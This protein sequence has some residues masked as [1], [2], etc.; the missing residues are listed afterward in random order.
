MSLIAE[1]IAK[2]TLPEEFVPSEE[3]PLP[4]IRKDDLVLELINY[5]R[6]REYLKDKP[7]R[8]I[9]DLALICRSVVNTADKQVYAAVIDR[10]V[11]KL[12]A[13]S[14]DE[15]FRIA[16][17]PDERTH[18]VQAV[19]GISAASCVYKR[20]VLPRLQC[21]SCKKKDSARFLRDFRTTFMCCRHRSMN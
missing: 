13:L 18:A 4:L 3:V 8:R 11:M 17:R 14:E 9:L 2:H 7:H 15:L 12:L 10:E 5:E 20:S 19:S 1:I 6:N 21:L 16:Q